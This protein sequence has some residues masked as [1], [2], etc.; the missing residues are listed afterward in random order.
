MKRT[1]P[2]LLLL[3]GLCCCSKPTVSVYDAPKDEAPAM[4]FEAPSVARPNSLAWRAPSGWKEKAGDGMRLATLLP[5]AED[6]QAE[7]SIVQLEGEAGGDLA[8]VNRWRGQLGLSS[9]DSLAGSEP[10]TTKAGKAL[11]VD[12]KGDDKRMIAAILKVGGA[13][14]FFKLS[15]PASAVA[16]A[17]PGFLS[18]LGTLHRGD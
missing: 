3:S 7:L 4:P 9:T 15:G 5:P 18:F 13:T 6:G 14:W 1:F 2:L 10:V 12:L 16:A 8:N 17:K 11:L